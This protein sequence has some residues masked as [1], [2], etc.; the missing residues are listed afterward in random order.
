MEI[1]PKANRKFASGNL[2]LV[3][4]MGAGKSTMG[5]VLAKH[6][7]KLFVDSDVEIQERTGVTIPHIFDVEGEDGF[8]QRESSAI[9]AI[10]D[11]N[12]VV[13]AT[14]GGAIL[15]EGNRALLQGGGIV[16]YLQANV[17]ELWQRT[18]HDK[19]RP[20]LQTENPHA[21]LTELFGQR[22]PLYREIADVV[23]QTGRQS[24][25]SLM[26]QLVDKL[27]IFRDEQL[28]LV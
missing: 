26:L 23:I 6:T 25:H 20:L 11:G 28:R 10:L 19:N 2:I 14:G 24:V 13:L 18:R 8:R 9:Q 4:M 7:G 21:K 17:N 12:N 1:Q 16:I 15:S 22:D 27:D 3:G 5:R